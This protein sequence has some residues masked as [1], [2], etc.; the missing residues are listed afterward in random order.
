MFPRLVQSAGDPP[1]FVLDVHLGR[2]AG[3]LRLLGI[4]SAYR[5]DAGDDALAACAL[6]ED[7]VLLTRDTGRSSALDSGRPPSFTPPRR[8]HSWPK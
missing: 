6:A 2:L 4:D 1:R 8:S 3:Y 5:N 7:R